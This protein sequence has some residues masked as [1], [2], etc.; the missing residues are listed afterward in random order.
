MDLAPDQDI[1][2]ER[3]GSCLL[4]RCD[5]QNSLD[6]SSQKQL[7]RSGGKDKPPYRNYHHT[8]R[9]FDAMNLL[10][11]QRLLCDVILVADTVEIPAHKMVLAACSPYFY[12]MFTSFEESKQDRIV[13]QEVDHQALQILVEYVYTSEVQVT[14]DNVQVLLPAANLLQLTDVRDAC[15]EFLQV[16]L[17]PTNCLGIRAFAD[18]HGCLELLAHAES[19]IEQHFIEVV[20]CEEFLTLSHQQVSKLICS[21]RLTV[22]SEEQVFECVIAWVQHDL[23]ARHKHLAS[24]MEHVRLPLMSQEYLMQRVEEEPLLK[25]DL[26]CKDYIIEA[27]KYHLLKGDNKTTF[28]TPRTK[29]RQP[30]G[31]PKVLLVVGGQAPKAIRSVECYDFKE[32]KWYQVAEMPTRRCRAGLAVLHGKVYAVGGFNGSLR[33]RTVDV[34]DAALDQWNTC[35]HMEARRSTLGVAVLG[36]CIYAV[37]GFDGSTGLNTAEMYDPTTAKW[38]SIAPMSTRRSSVGVGVLYGILYAVGGYDG[39]SRQCLSSVECYTPE[40]DCWTSVPDMGCRRSGAGVGVLEGV[41]YAVGGHDGP[42][43]RK[44]VEA[45]DPVK[46]LWTAVSDMTFCRRNAGVVALNGLLYVVGGD[47]G[48]SNLS[49]V[50]VYNPKTDTWTLLPSCMGIGRSYAGVAIIDKPI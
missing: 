18:L 12:A 49:S 7:P 23:D 33:V 22:P 32:E 25:A 2:M 14:E 41:L 35:D 4:L 15:C 37:G 34:Y 29:P 1:V 26:Q 47:D 27:L 39:A 31:L 9:A 43:V 20:E 46:R 13:L 11:K 5:S 8:Q 30:V 6:E 24:L 50:E 21:D 48:C 38:R 40:I 45:Y 19:Y 3:Q 36:N 28:R 17:H 16:Q 44:S 42:Q 10:R